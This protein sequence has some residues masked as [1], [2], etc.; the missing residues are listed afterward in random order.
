MRRGDPNVDKLGSA[1]YWPTYNA[2]GDY[3]NAPVRLN[4]TFAFANVSANATAPT[5]TAVEIAQ[6]AQ[7]ERCDY[8]QSYDYVSQAKI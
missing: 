7:L 2:L 5:G 4:P 6:L 3:L 8:L 1:P